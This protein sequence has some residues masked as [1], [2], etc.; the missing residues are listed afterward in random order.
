MKTA[1]LMLSATLLVGCVSQSIR[2]ELPNVPGESRT[3]G[4]IKSIAVDGISQ[5]EDSEYKCA[6]SEL[7][8]KNTKILRS[9]TEETTEF[10]FVSSC[11]GK[12]H[13]YHVTYNPGKGKVQISHQKYD[14][15]GRQTALIIWESPRFRPPKQPLLI[16]E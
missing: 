5:L 7:V 8:I 15:S 3:T 14:K 6:R 4:E 1:L 11:V 16:F 10:W 2:P 13:E 12:V 9:S